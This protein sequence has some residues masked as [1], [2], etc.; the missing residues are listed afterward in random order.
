ML[1]GKELQR[2]VFKLRFASP[3]FFPIL[4]IHYLLVLNCCLSVAIVVSIHRNVF[5]LKTM[6]L[7]VH[8]TM[9]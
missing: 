4:T 3:S 1:R 8:M 9:N 7:V 6:R 2:A 5:I